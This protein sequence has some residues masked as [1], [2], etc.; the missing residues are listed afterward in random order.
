MANFKTNEM[1]EQQI[2]N[3]DSQAFKV[4]F[5]K[6]HGSLLGYALSLTQDRQQAEDIVQTAF[7][8]LWKKRKTLHPSGFRKLL[9]HTSK[10]L[11]IDQYRSSI[12]RANLYAELTYDALK[13]E[14]EDEEYQQQQIIKLRKIIETLPERCQQILRMT[15]LEG[16]SQQETADYLSIS[17]R[18]VQAQI[19]VAYKKIREMFNNDEPTILFFL[20]NAL[21]SMGLPSNQKKILGQ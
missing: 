10:N 6:Y 12:S 13:E 3:G 21:Q 15:K 5:E 1:L 9:Y 4:F 16:L 7:V 8:T 2:I 18:T 17:P 19:H 11:Y 20:V 14:P